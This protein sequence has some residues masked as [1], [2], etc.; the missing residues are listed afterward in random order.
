MHIAAGMI[1][2][3]LLGGTPGIFAIC[4]CTRSFRYSC[5]SGSAKSSK[6]RKCARAVNSSWSTF[7]PC[8]LVQW[9]IDSTIKKDT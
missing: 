9:E 5:A 6:V 2:V 4:G 8:G 3:L 7:C 1:V